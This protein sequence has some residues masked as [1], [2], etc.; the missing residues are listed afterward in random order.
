[1]MYEMRTYNGATRTTYRPVMKKTAGTKNGYANV[2]DRLAKYL[3]E[4]NKKR[5]ENK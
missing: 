4:E 2:F 1:M 5:E 3:E